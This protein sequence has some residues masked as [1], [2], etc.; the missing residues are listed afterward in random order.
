MFDKIPSLKDFIIYFIPGALICFFIIEIAHK[1][2][3]TTNTSNF[4]NNNNLKVFIGV[5]ISFL[6][7]F[8]S[9]QSHIIIFTKILRKNNENMRT[10]ALLDF[11]TDL[12]ESLIERVIRE[13]GLN[14]LNEDGTNL[15]EIKKKLLN[16]NSLFFLCLQYVKV[17]TNI[18]CL[19]SI[20]RSDYM[21]TF[22]STLILPYILG[23]TYFLS[24]V[25]LDPCCVLFSTMVLTSI[26]ITFIYKTIVN[27][28]GEW[29]KVIFR[30]FMIL[31]K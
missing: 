30:Q 25:G 13:F 31:S 4:I 17:K 24:K 20:D 18:E 5:L 7:G 2:I 6:V 28:R 1:Y 27:F 15:N 21:A 10:L 22:S 8:I 26:F 29:Y 12:K 11:D 9:S 19:K 3:G 23:C 14:P 16:D